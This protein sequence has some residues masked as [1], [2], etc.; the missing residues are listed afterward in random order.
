MESPDVLQF[1]EIEYRFSVATWSD[2]SIALSKIRETVFI[3]EQ[4]VPVELEWDEHDATAWHFL[5]TEHVQHTSTGGE[6]I[7]TARLLPDGHF[8]RMAVLKPYRLKGIGTFL[9]RQVEAF[10]KLQK[11][12]RIDLAA[13][14]HAIGFYHQLGYSLT[15][16]MF[17]DAGIP[18]RNMFKLLSEE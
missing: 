14:T 8:G 11:L 5:I 16:D 3:Q 12:T 6:V 13:Q 10:A 9:I 2:K 15:G 18:H 17:M 7:A 4:F 1:G